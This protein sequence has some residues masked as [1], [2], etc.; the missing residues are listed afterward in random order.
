MRTLPLTNI[1]P[2]AMATITPSSVPRKL[3]SSL[4]FRDTARQDQ[5]RLHAL[6]QN[7]EKDE[8]ENDP[9]H[10]SLPCQQ[11]DLAFNLP[12]QLR[13]VFIMKMIMVMTKKAAA[14]MIQPS[15]IS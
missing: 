8:Q 1:T 10:A 3:S 11:S 7:H 6:A 4:E 9:N 5:H 2:N 12:F 14:S 15:K 13:P